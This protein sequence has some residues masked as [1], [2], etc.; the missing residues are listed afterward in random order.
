[1]LAHPLTMRDLSDAVRGYVLR[2]GAFFAQ[3]LRADLAN[4]GGGLR[5]SA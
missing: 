2:D 1:M 5:R 4:Y 3:A